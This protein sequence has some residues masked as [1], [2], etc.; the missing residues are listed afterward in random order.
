MMKMMKRCM[1]VVPGLAGGGGGDVVVEVEL[2]TVGAH[3]LVEAHGRGEDCGAA[4]VAE[5]RSDHI[6]RND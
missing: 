3:A 6:K 2:L 4:A 1:K 5:E